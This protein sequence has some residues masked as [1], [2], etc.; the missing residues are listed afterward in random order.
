[1]TE[2]K[3]C[4]KPAEYYPDV[5]VNGEKGVGYYCPV[6]ENKSANTDPEKAKEEFLKNAKAAP[7]KTTPKK[8]TKP[9]NN[10]NTDLAPRGLMGQA[11]EYLKSEEAKSAIIRMASPIVKNETGALERLMYNN[12]RYVE[13]AN[14]GKVWDSE[15]G[16]DSIIHQTEE[17]MIMGIE[18]GKMGDLVPYG[19]VCQLI[20]SVEAYKFVLTNG[21]NSP[22][23]DLGIECIHENDQ[24]TSGVKGKSFF[25]DLSKGI[26][27]G[28]IIGVIVWAERRD[29]KTIGDFY[30]ADRLMDKAEAH[31]ISYQRYKQDLM[32]FESMKAEGKIN[33]ENG[34]EYF[35]KQMFKK[36]GGTWD[37]KIF[38]DELRNPYD[39]PDKPEMLRKSAGKSFLA[40]YMKVRNSEAA[41]QEARTHEDVRDAAMNG[42]D[43]TIVDGVAE[44]L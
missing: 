28:E 44:I 2:I 23:V 7:K 8:E 14:L 26:P 35:M 4:G 27:R 5:E 18:L 39:G 9:M 30:D 22:F 43:P 11:L 37:K 16:K 10:N 32:A 12:V 21:N 41:M 40:P 38:R 24:V 29:G 42:N 19:S 25:F 33:I 1:M 31:S 6:C 3:C 34:R 13:N 17:A 20:P 15:E 36:G